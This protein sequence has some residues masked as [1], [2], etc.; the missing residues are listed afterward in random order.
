MIDIKNSIISKILNIVKSN[1]YAFSLYCRQIAGTI[2]LFVIARY[3][4]VYDYGIFSSY[5]AI[6]VTILIF[7]CLGYNEY[8]LISS[9][10]NVREVRLKISLFIVNAIIIILAAS[11]L[12]FLCPVE[13]HVVFVL[14][15]LRTFFDTTFFT[16]ILPYFQA[17]N[18]FDIISYINITYGILIFIVTLISYIFKLSLTKFL[19]LSCVI[20]LFNFIQCSLYAGINYLS[21]LFN[22]KKYLK[23]ID[24]S[25]FTYMSSVALFI[26]FA[27]LPHLY[28]SAFVQKEE[29]ALY[30]ASST[31]SGIIVL[32]ISAQYQKIVPEL[33]NSCRVKIETVIKKNLKNVTVI[34]LLIFIFFCFIGKYLLTLIYG[35]EYYSRGYLILLLFTVSNIS[36][37]LATIY[38]AYITASGN[39]K[40][41]VK[42]QIVATF[43]VVLM[44]IILHKYGIYAASISYLTAIT[45]I[46]IVYYLK[47]KE[48]L[49]NQ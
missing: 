1:L 11:G 43:I 36:F 19:I 45:Y 15:L 13:R 41:K 48:L 2:I 40:I 24:K 26:F 31:I 29:A 27:Q 49:K 4:S 22:V 12:S 5:K 16:L 3:L 44:L 7:A 33:M 38:G 9:N 42:T 35:Q 37:S 14:V 20:G 46:G 30:F 39:Q 28:V 25:I 47:T 21:P 34:N 8:I 6:S 32:L 10:K 18:K 17:S 23:L